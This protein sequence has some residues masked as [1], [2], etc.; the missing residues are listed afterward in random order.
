MSNGTYSPFASSSCTPPN[1]LCT[2]ITPSTY[3]TGTAYAQLSV[4][5]RFLCEKRGLTNSSADQT[6]LLRPA[7]TIP[8]HV[9][10][11]ESMMIVA[12]SIANN[13]PCAP[14]RLSAGVRWTQVP[15]AHCTTYSNTSPIPPTCPKLVYQYV[16]K[17]RGDLTL[18]VVLEWWLSMNRYAS[19]PPVIDAPAKITPRV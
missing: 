3:I 15:I 19:M 14:V 11:N 18:C 9:S 17:S 13:A 8:S 6:S 10:T 7:E 16:R 1:L 2:V 12:P 5:F 4:N